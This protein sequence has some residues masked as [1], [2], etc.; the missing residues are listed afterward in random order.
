MKI[1]SVVGTRPNFVKEFFIHKELKNRNVKEILV[2][3]GQHYDYEMSKIFFEDFN[4]AKPD[5][6]FENSNHSSIRQVASTMVY[7]ED[8]LQKEK[9]DCTLIYGDVNATLSAAIA[10]AKL[11]IPVA[12]IEGGVRSKSLYNPEEINRRVSD[13]LSSL[14][15]TCTRTDYNN[16]LKENFSKDRV[17]LSGDIM[18]D[19]VLHTVKKN[20]IEVKRGDYNVVTVHREENVESEERLTRIVSGL[21]IS[22]AKIVFPAHPRTRKRLEEFD[23]IDKYIKN[24]NIELMEPRGYTEFIKLLAGANK[25]ITDS[26]GVR[27]EGYILEKPVLVL[28]DITWFP[29][30]LEAGWKI[31]VDTDP[32][33]IAE[34]INKF[35]PLNV[36][37][38][39]FGDGHA[40][41]IIVDS[42]V[43]RFG[44]Q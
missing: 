14:I 7:M 25:V 39:I 6:H 30:I 16:L 29:E 11:R 34:A 38:E 40:Y 23:L 22:K 19:V 41:E 36:H 2:H 4:I 37:S 28:I 17:V 12:H 18:K 10:S 43:S 44:D 9:P 32:E 1:V 24:S 42:L 15:F 27:R 20:N 8:V 26:G 13:Q 33:K 21:C 35:E 3:T 31:I 5:Y